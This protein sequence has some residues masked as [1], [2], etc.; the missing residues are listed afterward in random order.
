MN[1][2]ELVQELERKL[3][4]AVEKSVQHREKID[5]HQSELNRLSTFVDNINGVI[6]GLG[7]SVEEPVQESGLTTSSREPRDLKKPEFSKKGYIA[8]TIE[9][10][11]PKYPSGASIDKLI[12]DGFDYATEDELE[13]IKKSYAVELNRAFRED[14]IYKDE[15]ENFYSLENKPSIQGFSHDQTSDG[16]KS[17]IISLAV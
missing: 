13:K 12:D 3:E 5:Y 15:N 2:H 16:G 4:D 1:N 8:F 9:D 6:Q 7:V 11:L 14:R 17:D 10:L